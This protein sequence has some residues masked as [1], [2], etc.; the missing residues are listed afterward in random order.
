V[1]QLVRLL[2]IVL[3]CAL[4]G[5]VDPCGNDVLKE[6]PSADGRLKAVVFQRDCGAT[7]G[8][9]TQVTI[10]RSNERL[11]ARP[12]WLHSTEP[13]AFVAD[14]NQGQAP[15][16]AGGGPEVTVQWMGPSRLR[17][18]HHTEAR[19][20]LRAPSLSGVVFEVSTQDR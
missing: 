10:L 20:F 5:C 18:S 6:V 12:T 9:S 16:G 15:S 1:I 2:G 19:T 11:L 7:T 13:G 8:L 4:S 14:T 17:I 3:L